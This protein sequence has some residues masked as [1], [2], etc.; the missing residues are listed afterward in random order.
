MSVLLIG[1]CV[2]IEVSKNYNSSI[3]RKEPRFVSA[4]ISGQIL[5]LDTYSK[6]EIKESFQS[7]VTE[8]KDFAEML[9]KYNTP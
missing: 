1:N 6:E 9:I 3:Q 8:H 5:S 2:F 7:E 4:T